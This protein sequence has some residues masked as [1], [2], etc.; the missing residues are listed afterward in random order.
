MVEL[1]KATTILDRDA[2]WE[3]LRSSEVGRLG[4][5]IKNHPDIFPVNYV[6]DG[7]S[8]V[9]RTEAGTKLAG[10]VLGVSVAFEADG[11][12]DAEAWSVVIKGRATEI[13]QM[14]ELFDAAELPLYPWHAAPKHRWVRIVAD[15][16]T[17]RRFKIVDRASLDADE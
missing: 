1:S 5:S 9:F 11:V 14:Q 8:V 17:G 6:V 2:C 15:E 16:I 13:E 10:A 3:H 12:T 4:I 7:D